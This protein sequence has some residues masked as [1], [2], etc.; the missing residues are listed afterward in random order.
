MF[1]AL[2]QLFQQS[3]ARDRVLATLFDQEQAGIPE[4]SSLSVG[5]NAGLEAPWLYR[6]LRKLEDQGLIN[7]RVAGP[8]QAARG[9]RP[10]Y[11]YR[12]TE[13]GRAKAKTSGG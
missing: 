2:K 7:H 8:R 5:A 13:R 6:A 12:L 11:F 1:G 9:G 4:S 10:A 3:S